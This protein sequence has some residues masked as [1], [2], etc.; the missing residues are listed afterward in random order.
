MGRQRQWLGV[1][2]MALGGWML[3]GCVS[4]PEYAEPRQSLAANLSVPERV[5]RPQ[6]Q[7]VPAVQLKKPAGFGESTTTAPPTGSGA[8]QTSFAS[9]GSLRVKVRAWV[10]G[11]PI[12]EDEV[13]QALA[14]PDLRR[15]QSLPEPQ[16]SEEMAKL[17]N[18]VID[19]LIDQ[20]LMFQDAVKKLEKANPRALDKMKDEVE[21]DLDRSVQRMRAANV[22]EDDIRR[23]EPTARRM[24]ER[25]TISA[26]YARSR[27]MPTVQSL[28]TLT[29]IREHY[30]A[31]LEDYRSEDKVAWQDIFIPTGANLPTLEDARRF[32]EEL[33]N[34]CRT[35]D[36]FNR[37]MVYDDRKVQ[38]CEGIGS[39]RGE[40]KPAEVED[41]LFKLRDG[42]IGPVILISTGVHLIRVTK[43]EYKGQRLLDDAVQKE[44]RRKLE[45]EL[46]DREYRRIA[47]DLRQRAVWWIERDGQ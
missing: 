32:A 16:A 11:R 21:K 14:G 31:H 28:I 4:L 9:R 42:E 35:Q 13:M 27:I 26:I 7:D 36:D 25:N 23:L 24:M 29:Q 38:N 18:S 39:R 20:E 45:G 40:I 6:M 44:I 8:V 46:M 33:V 2:V 34:R 19:N 22:P 5:A 37:L 15:V 43:R 41:A 3:S 30:E 47:R 1:G 12:F 10:N 17:M